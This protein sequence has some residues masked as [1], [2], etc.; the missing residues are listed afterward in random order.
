M[1]VEVLGDDMSDYT[2]SMERR[3]NR[4]RSYS[5]RRYLPLSVGKKI[6]F[7]QAALN[8]QMFGA[9]TSQWF[10]LAKSAISDTIGAIS[11][12][13]TPTQKAIAA[14]L[15]PPPPPKPNYTPYYMIGGAI[16]IGTLIMVGTRRR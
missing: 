14:E 8:T 16:L 5:K 4:I 9:D 6:A 7:S 1:N 3:L 2:T 10:D 12:R 15:P 11:S 13:L